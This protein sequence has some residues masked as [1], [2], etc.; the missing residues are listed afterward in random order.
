MSVRVAD[1]SESP[2]QF[3]DTARQ[4]A[5]I[6]CSRMERFLDKICK[7][8]NKHKYI[9][10]KIYGYY[11]E[12][13]T[14]YSTEAYICVSYANRIH[15]KDSKSYERREKQLK[16]AIEYYNKLTSVISIVFKQFNKS[17]NM[18]AISHIINMIN[19]EVEQ[20]KKIMQ[21]DKNV[22]KSILG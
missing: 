14:K 20:I 8:Y 18:N 6:M 19:I 13:T 16:E 1:R 10:R 2:I 17:F 21:H 12:S 4:I 3:I 22:L 11:Y 5:D 7:K 9:A 15:I